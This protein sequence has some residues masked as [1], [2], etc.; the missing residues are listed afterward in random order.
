MGRK[1][2]IGLQSRI[3]ERAAL[4]RRMGDYSCLF[5]CLCSIADEYRAG[6]GTGGVNPLLL[7][8]DARDGGHLD[9]EWTCDTT[10]ILRLA[11]GVRWT[12][13]EAEN[14]PAH[15]PADMYTV[16]KW[17]NG[18]TGLTHFRRRWG[19][20]VRDSV[21]VREGELVGYYIFEPKK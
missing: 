1:D 10:E 8:L 9:D 21:T 7:A 6:L 16:E 11:T 15:V 20:T 2:Y 13:R 17:R 12:K 4:F 3:S 19:D 5:L 14:L 18:R